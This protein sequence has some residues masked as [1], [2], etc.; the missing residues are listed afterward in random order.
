MIKEKLN[1]YLGRKELSKKAID[2]V[3]V[4][5]A[6]SEY[7]SKETVEEL[8]EVLF[9]L[10]PDVIYAYVCNQLEKV[11]DEQLDYFIELCQKAI[12]P[13]KFTH[14]FGL[15]IAL[16]KRLKNR[17]SNT[18]ISYLVQNYI[19]I[20]KV[21]KQIYVSFERALHYDGADC[22]FTK[23]T[24]EDARIKNGYR[25]LLIEFLS[26]YPNPEYAD[27]VTK[28]YNV[29]GLTIHSSEQ[30]IIAAALKQT[31]T[32]FFAHKEIAEVHASPP[33]KDLGDL[34]Q[35]PLAQLLE[36]VNDKSLQLSKKADELEFENKKLKNTEVSL[37]DKL[38]S[39][40]LSLKAAENTITSL[41]ERINANENTIADLKRDLF[42]DTEKIKQLN[43]VIDEL[44]SK[45][46][47]VE[48][49]Y[50]YAGQQEIDFLKGQIKKRLTL[51]Y[52]KYLE[53]KEK[54]P[55]L[56]YYDILLDMLDEIYHVLSKN[57]IKFDD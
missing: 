33:K 34:V 26:V 39:A 47:N 36:A 5:L 43:T 40:E 18:I 32:Q 8:V 55:D 6:E 23:W 48:S 14:A 7:V 37:T 31:N 29:N 35:I 51:E 56:D 53:L 38:K 41:H 16:C 21:N 24:G 57:G 13:N 17:E 9:R 22:F 52:S 30:E 46:T 49:A 20:K 42:A 44:N 25:K 4:I 50:G 15:S 11:S 2:E 27:S 1:T 45:L 19:L 28:W 10:K 54:S 3:N 12:N